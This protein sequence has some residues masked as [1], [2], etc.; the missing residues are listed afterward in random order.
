ML[1]HLDLFS[2]IGGFTLAAESIGG[3]RTEQFVE[4]DTDAQA[5]LRS[6]LDESCI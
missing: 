1:K 4:I 5:V 2:G 3:I 6:H